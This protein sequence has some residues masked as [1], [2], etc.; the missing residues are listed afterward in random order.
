MD[1]EQALS[2][3]PDDNRVAVSMFYIGDCSLRE[4][5]EFVLCGITVN[6]AHLVRKL[7]INSF[8]HPSLGVLF[9]LFK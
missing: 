1:L 9:S 3:L 4:I 8:C 5:S 2:E 6:D 7:I